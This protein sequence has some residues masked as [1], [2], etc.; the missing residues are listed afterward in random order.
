MSDS[1]LKF[2]IAVMPKLYTNL[3]LVAAL[4]LLALARQQDFRT[5]SRTCE[6]TSQSLINDFDVQL[7]RTLT[8]P[9]PRK[10]AE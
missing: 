9:R 7:P 4:T 8:F 1:H 10:V 3:S 6:Q 5:E 2:T